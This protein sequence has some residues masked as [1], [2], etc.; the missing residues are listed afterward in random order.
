ML[1]R[2]EGVEIDTRHWIGGRRV[3]SADRFESISPIDESVIAQVASGSAPEI[4]LAVI[5]AA[6]AFK[7]WKKTS[8]EERARL[9]HRVADIIESRIESLA[10][11]ETRDN[12]SLLRSHLHGV[13]PRVA[14]NFR[15][16]ADWLLQLSHP[17]F[18]VRGQIGRAHV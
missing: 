10:V 15:F 5:A 17:D 13:M 8:R 12:G 9:L 14:L 1:A 4:D 2:V 16:F 7:D 6:E 11:V 3:D 18:D